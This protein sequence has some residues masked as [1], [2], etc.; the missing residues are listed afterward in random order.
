[1]A[2]SKG[3]EEALLHFSTKFPGEVEVSWK[4]SSV[5]AKHELI[6]QDHI[7]MVLMVA[8]FSWV[9]LQAQIK[10]VYLVKQIINN[11]QEHLPLLP[12]I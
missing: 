4:L 2:Q 8:L 10:V 7:H 5:P 6:G 9:V 3:K 1:V 12:S 11:V